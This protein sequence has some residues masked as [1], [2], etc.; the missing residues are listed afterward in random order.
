MKSTIIQ[1]SYRRYLMLKRIKYAVRR[2]R[3]EKWAVCKLI[4]NLRKFVAKCKKRVYCINFIKR[5]LRN[6]VKRIT[7]K[8]IATLV[9]S[10]VLKQSMI[11][12]EK[13][14]ASL[15]KRIIKYVI[16]FYFYF[17][18]WIMSPLSTV[19]LYIEWK[20]C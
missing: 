11:I 7:I 10:V 15:T 4:L 16:L 5:K 1:R 9:R 6:Y 12:Q 3:R 18:N 20:M 19:L 8:R 17:L 2:I 13:L 14:F